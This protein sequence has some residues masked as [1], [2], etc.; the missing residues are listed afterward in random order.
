M[1][2]AL[3][4]RRRRAKLTE[5]HPRFVPTDAPHPAHRNAE[6]LPRR[7]HVRE[8]L[9][10]RFPWGTEGEKSKYIFHCFTATVGTRLR[11]NRGRPESDP[12][13]WGAATV[14]R[15]AKVAAHVAE[16][17]Q[18]LR[19]RRRAGA[20]GP[21]VAGGTCPALSVSDNHRAV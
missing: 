18:V 12:K 6:A 16:E 1:A 8:R 20:V 15:R 11:G 17:R 14:A 3:L 2:F 9:I 13:Y 7:Q 21:G 5:L 19:V 4:R 10:T